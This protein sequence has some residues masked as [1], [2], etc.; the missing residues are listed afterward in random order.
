MNAKA[1]NTL[2]FYKITEMLSA[3]AVSPMG[4][5]MAAELVPSN[6]ISDIHI[7][8]E[9][10]TAATGFIL[11]K[12]SLPLGGLADIRTS[13]TRA[14][15]GGTLFI[16]D[17]LHVCDFLYVCGKVITYGNEK[18]AETCLAPYFDGI[19]TAD[20]VEREISRCIKSATEIADSASPK[21]ADIRRNIKQSHD[22]VREQLQGIIR[23]E[24]YKNMLQ[25]PIVTL[26]GDRFCVPV[27]AEHRTAFPGMVHDQSSSGQTLFMEPLS[28]VER[29]NKIKELHFEEKREEE[30]ILAK[31]SGLVAGEAELLN[32]NMGLLT[33][34]DFV[35]AKGEL[36]LAMKASEPKFNS[37]GYIN[38]RKGRHPLLNPDR[39]VPTDIYLG[40]EFSMLLITGPNTGGK[41]VTL[42][43]VGLFTCMGQAGLHIPAFDNSELAVFDEVF[44]DIGDEQSIEQSL[45]T[46]SSH[47]SNIV[48]ILKEI[49]S[50]KAPNSL[51]L[52]DELGAGT[53]PTEG[54]A[55]AISILQYLHT[56]GIRTVVTTHYSEL[57]LYALSTAGVENASCEFDVETLRPTYRLLIGIPGKSNAFAIARRLGLSADIIDGA[58][59]VLSQKDA[60]FEDL[61]TDLE[62]GKKQAIIEQERAESFR[63]DAERLR[64]DTER[65]QEKL[66]T[67]REKILNAARAEAQETLRRAKIDAEALLVEMKKSLNSAKDIEGTRNAMRNALSEMEAN[68]SASLGA[69]DK[70]RRTPPAN[71]RKGDKVHVHSINQDGTVLVPPNATGEV[72]IQAGIMQM[73][74]Q[75]NDLSLVDDSSGKSF[76]KARE[77]GTL[78]RTAK[79]RTI[80][81]EIDLRGMTPEEATEKTD[82]YL[83]DAFLASLSQVT[84]IHGKGTGAVRNAVHV[85]LKRHAHVK[86]FRLGKYGEGETGVTVVTLK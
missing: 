11:R 56:Y 19:Q 82:K 25:D 59:G 76:V 29:N 51:V 60:R 27:K 34:L 57:K 70:P 2:E 47:L 17:L 46:F 72:L 13:V 33:H 3:R 24:Q 16:E 39:V 6:D 21:L 36:A 53:D 64:A 42:K 40:N 43:T 28:V 80:S 23:S 65:Q 26:R 54:A 8:Q 20:T 38:I 14:A 52:M 10:T 9:Q 44:A 18:G 74:V 48:G 67:Q 66:N 4:K 86:D 75:L 62:A 41:T 71:L 12:G 77:G 49:S 1:L 5:K 68:L 31:L 69:A 63:R 83:D 45:S 30:R 50:A 73:K 61:I 35:F 58:R 22:K 7:A 15:A 78:S 55:L 85:L 84:V 37:N 81:P 32:A 79:S